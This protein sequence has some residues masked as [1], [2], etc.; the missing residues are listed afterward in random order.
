MEIAS[1]CNFFGFFF[2]EK[3]K[4]ALAV[5]DCDGADYTESSASKKS[6]QNQAFFG[7]QTQGAGAFSY[8][9]G[10]VLLKKPLSRP[11]ELDIAKIQL[12]LSV[13]ICS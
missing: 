4:K 6:K 8:K 3:L 7:Q 9:F 12:R 5:S 13:G 10:G 1:D 2:S 11:Q